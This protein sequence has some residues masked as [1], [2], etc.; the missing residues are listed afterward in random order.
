MPSGLKKALILTSA[1]MSWAA[2]GD[3]TAQIMA[4]DASA[5]STAA[6]SHRSA[7][8]SRRRTSITPTLSGNFPTRASKGDVPG[9]RKLRRAPFGYSVAHG[10][11]APSCGCRACA[12]TPA[13]RV[14]PGPC[15][16]AQSGKLPPTRRNPAIGGEIRI[17]SRFNSAIIASTNNERLGGIMIKLLRQRT[18]V[19]GTALA[20]GIFGLGVGQAVLQKHAEAQGSTV[21][22]PVFEVDPLWPKPLPNNW[23]LGLDHR[24]LGRRTRS[25]LGH[26][27]RR[28]RAAQQ[29][30]AAPSSIRRSPS[31]AA[32]PRPILV[33]DS[34]GSCCGRGAVR[35]TAT[36]GRSPITAS[37]STTRAMSGSA[38]MARRMRTS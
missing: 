28:R 8:R 37:T 25:H 10:K 14:P 31:A 22:A 18:F 12:P 32:P 20:A 26:P 7:I 15:S 6:A 3:A 36:S 2:A 16:A 38:A 35:A 5:A 24:H 11:Q 19:Y 23:L 1:G 33:Y 27:S 17:P 34:D 4:T 29:R 30:D 9:G 13:Q 21:Q